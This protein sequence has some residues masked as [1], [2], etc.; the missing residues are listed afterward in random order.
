M[1]R[2][3]LARDMWYNRESHHII[4]DESHHISSQ[5]VICG[6]IMIHLTSAHITSAHITV[7]HDMRCEHIMNHA[8]HQLNHL[9]LARDMWNNHESIM[10]HHISSPHNIISSHHISSPHISLVVQS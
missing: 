5:L 7:A 6:A 3:Q 1:N 4:P 2:T 10:N 9:T 8:S